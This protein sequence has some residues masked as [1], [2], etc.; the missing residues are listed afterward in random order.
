MITVPERKI[1]S[2]AIVSVPLSHVNVYISGF[3]YW[4]IINRLGRKGGGVTHSSLALRLKPD[5][6]KPVVC[7][8]WQSE[9]GVCETFLLSCLLTSCPSPPSL[10]TAASKRAVTEIAPCHFQLP[11]LQFVW[12]CSS[13]LSSLRPYGGYKLHTVD[14]CAGM[15]KGRVCFWGGSAH[16][17]PHRHCV[18]PREE[19][20]LV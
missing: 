14:R 16:F 18:P 19:V 1:N 20:P 2:Q 5:V 17:C 9:V 10:F 3:S 7:H 12:T 4:K 6:L 15:C 8:H 13:V 11:H